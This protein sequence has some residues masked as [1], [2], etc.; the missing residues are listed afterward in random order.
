MC[1]KKQSFQ[2]LQVVLRMLQKISFPTLL[3]L[4][5]GPC[6]MYHLRWPKFSQRYAIPTIG[7][8]QLLCF[9]SIDFAVAEV[10]HRN[11]FVIHGQ[12]R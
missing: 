4:A 10:R 9:A 3:L 5:Y 8:I 2:F 1:A 11:F 12:E 7:H 6:Q